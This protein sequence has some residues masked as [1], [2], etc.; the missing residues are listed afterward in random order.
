MFTFVYYTIT[1]DFCP[2]LVKRILLC[3]LKLDSFLLFLRT[4]VALHMYKWSTFSVNVHFV[5]YRRW[6]TSD[7]GP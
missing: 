2:I 4:M 3:N 7:F 5:R 1:F 6:R